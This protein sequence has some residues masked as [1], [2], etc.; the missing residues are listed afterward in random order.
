VLDELSDLSKE[1]GAWFVEDC[2]HCLKAVSG[3]GEFGDFVL[4]SPHKLLAIPDGGL[5]VV[6]KEGAGRVLDN[7]ADKVVLEEIYQQWL[8]VVAIHRYEIHW[9]G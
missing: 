4:Y 2:A 3:V 6:R 1:Y 7:P 8:V 5:L 9:F